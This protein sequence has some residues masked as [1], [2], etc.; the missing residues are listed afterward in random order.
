MIFVM[1]ALYPLTIQARRVS[2]VVMEDR[3]MTTKFVGRA[4]GPFAVGRWE[5]AAHQLVL[6]LRTRAV[7]MGRANGPFAVGRWESAA[8]VERP[9][10]WP[11]LSVVRCIHT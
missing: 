9:P 4:N 11:L 8:H 5:S 10:D 3:D 2:L 6:E 7:K 1:I